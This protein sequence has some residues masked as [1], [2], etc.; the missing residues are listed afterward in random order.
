MAIPGGAR[1]QEHTLSTPRQPGDS[2][3][4]PFDLEDAATD[5][6]A[7]SRLITQLAATD[8]GTRAHTAAVR[9][10]QRVA[11]LIS[12]RITQHLHCTDQ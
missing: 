4:R 7:A 6:L 12:A 8:D 11:S 10:A 2:L 3:Q 9:D 1:H 5:L